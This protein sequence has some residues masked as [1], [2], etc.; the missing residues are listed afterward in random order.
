L[1]CPPS[2]EQTDVLVRRAELAGWD[3]SLEVESASFADKAAEEV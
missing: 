2:E 3:I 1:P